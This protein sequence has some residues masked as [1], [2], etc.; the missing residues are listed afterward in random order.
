MKPYS[1]D[2]LPIQ[3]LD[4]KSLFALVG[5]A[6]A[7]LACYDGLLPHN[8]HIGKVFH[9]E[10]PLY[11]SIAI[12]E[13]IANAL[14]HQDMTITGAGPL[15]EMFR[16]RLEI[17]NPGQPLVSPERFLDSPPR[18]P[19]RGVRLPNAPYAAVRG[20]GNRDRQG[21]CCRRAAPVAAAGFPDGG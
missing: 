14:I 20:T 5:D 6:N 4:Y 8:E 11:P 13:L 9:E 3:N 1:A 17:T 19:Q 12:R 2:T 21:D 7:E 16:D 18:L 10:K 15:I